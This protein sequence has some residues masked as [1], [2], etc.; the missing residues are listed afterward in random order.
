[1]GNI[2]NDKF[3]ELDET[4]GRGIAISIYKNEYGIVSASKTKSGEIWMDWCYP[5]SK[6]GPS[7]KRFPL[8]ITL[9]LKEQAVQLLEKLIYMIEGRTT[10]QPE[11]K[12]DIPF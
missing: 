12:D 2:D 9:G 6:N 10:K 4:K 1:M 7:D 11:N 3:I 5:A 8:K